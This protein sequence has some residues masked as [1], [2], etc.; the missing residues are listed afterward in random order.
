[1]QQGFFHGYTYIL[2]SS[3]QKSMPIRKVEYPYLHQAFGL[4]GSAKAEPIMFGIFILSIP[5]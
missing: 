3:A 4:R 1:M 2:V 5:A